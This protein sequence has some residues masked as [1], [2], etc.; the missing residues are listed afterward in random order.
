MSGSYPGIVLA[1][2]AP[3]LALKG[4]LTQRDSG[5]LLTRKLLVIAQFTISIIL[6][7]GTIGIN[8]QINYAIHSDLGYN[9]S[10]IVMVS[11]PEKLEPLKLETLKN[12]IAQSPDVENIT[13][14]FASPGAGWNEWGTSLKFNNSS[15]TEEFSIHAKMGDIN[16]LKTFNLSLIAGRNFYEKDSVDEIL[17]NAILAKKLNLSSPEELLGKSLEVS[18]GYIKGTIVGVVSDFHDQDFHESINPIFIAPKNGYNELAIK[19]NMKNSVEVLQHI[20]NEWSQAFPN[21]IFEYDFLEDRVAEL[22]ESEQRFL[23]LTKL[24]S[25]LAIFIGC[26]GIYGLILFFVIHKTKEIGIRKVLGGSVLHIIRLVT[27]G[28]LRLIIIAGVIAS[29]VAWYFMNSWLQNYN[30]KTEISLWIFV[31]AIAIVTFITL[32]TISYQAIKAALA[33]PVESLRSE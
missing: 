11:M 26:L 22:Y 33:N 31:L 2:I 7:I 9:K 24:F 18:G 5:G 32:L 16:Y 6:I 21:F 30:Y 23:A 4:K 13:A 27:K 8:K 3:L 14:C 19:I 29:P 20:E 12:Q 17:V 15:E 1:R 10:E 28:F 25:G